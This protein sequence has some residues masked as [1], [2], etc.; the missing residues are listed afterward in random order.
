MTH[1]YAIDSSLFS[2]AFTSA[3]LFAIIPTFSFLLP[4]EFHGKKKEI[5]NFANNHV[6]KKMNTV[7]SN[8][9]EWEIRDKRIK[10]YCN[11]VMIFHPSPFVLS[12]FLLINRK[13]G[14][15]YYYS[16]IVISHYLTSQSLC[17]LSFDSGHYSYWLPLNTEYTKQIHSD[18]LIPFRIRFM[19]M[20]MCASHQITMNPLNG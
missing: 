9:I 1:Y 14:S 20:S 8:P 11:H 5:F 6:A 2:S 18:E 13:Y 7:P 3:A 19:P 10:W 17:Y 16:C 15:T 4:R 12:F